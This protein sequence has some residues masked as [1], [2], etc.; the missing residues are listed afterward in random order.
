MFVVPQAKVLNIHYLRQKVVKQPR[1]GNSSIFA[2][3]LSVRTMFCNIKREK[4]SKI[5]LIDHIVLELFTHT[6]KNMTFWIQQYHKNAKIA[7]TLFSKF[8][9]KIIFYF[10][11]HWYE[12]VKKEI[13]NFQYK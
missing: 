10:P 7:K 4:S 5:F 3:L 8:D 2:Y 1:I 6:A 9:S 13:L 12:K 11:Y